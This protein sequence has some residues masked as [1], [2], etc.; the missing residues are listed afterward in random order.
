MNALCSWRNGHIGGSIYAAGVVHAPGYGL[1]PGCFQDEAIS[2]SMG[3]CIRRI[4][5]VVTGEHG[6]C[7]GTGEMYVVV[8]NRV[9]LSVDRHSHGNGKGRTCG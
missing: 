4:E 5:G 2:P 6:G 7:I 1:I 8:D 3:T 9:P